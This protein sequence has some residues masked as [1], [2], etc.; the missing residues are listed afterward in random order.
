MLTC[1]SCGVAL[2][3]F[4]TI[5]T[6]NF[7]HRQTD[8]CLSQIENLLRSKLCCLVS[9]VCLSRNERVKKNRR[10][11]KIIRSTR[12][13]RRWLRCVNPAV[14]WAIGPVF[15]A[16]CVCARLLPLSAAE[17]FALERNW[18]RGRKKPIEFSIKVPHGISMLISVVLQWKFYWIGAIKMSGS[19]GGGDA[20]EDEEEKYNYY[21]CELNR[22]YSF[23]FV[24]F[25][26]FPSHL[27]TIEWVMLVDSNGLCVICESFKWYLWQQSAWNCFEYFPKNSPFVLRVG[28]APFRSRY[29]VEYFR[30]HLRHMAVISNWFHVIECPCGHATTTLSAGQFF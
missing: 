19:V 25:T 18:I 9:D 27:K 22:S 29:F 26:D 5:S 16:R 1:K 15:P 30:F 17:W 6:G 7:S 21:E 28:C 14:E 20:T 11:K 23:R 4:S 2:F 8:V 3:W 13:N 10:K 24:F 12:W